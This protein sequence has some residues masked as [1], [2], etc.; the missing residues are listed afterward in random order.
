[1]PLTMASAANMT[2]GKHSSSLGILD[3]GPP[4]TVAD[5]GASQAP[6]AQ[7][8]PPAGNGGRGKEFRDSSSPQQGCTSTHQKPFE[9]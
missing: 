1:M 6:G 7:A 5:A 2:S 4:T 8:L 3:S 9:N